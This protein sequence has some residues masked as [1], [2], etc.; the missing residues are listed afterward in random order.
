MRSL[1]SASFAPSSF[2]LSSFSVTRR[3]QVLFSTVAITS[4]IITSSLNSVRCIGT[5][6]H[7]VIGH[8]AMSNIKVAR[9]IG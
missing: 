4:S 2:T 9:G 1:L 7:V 5:Q 6:V 8:V 3:P